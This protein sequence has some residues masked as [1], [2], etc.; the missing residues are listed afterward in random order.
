MP[1]RG[2][3]N[4]VHRNPQTITDSVAG[5][6]H[7]RPVDGAAPERS[8]QQF[9]EQ[10]CRACSARA[11]DREEHDGVAERVHERVVH[12]PGQEQRP[13]V[14]EPGELDGASPGPVKKLRRIE[15]SSGNAMNPT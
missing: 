13:V 9:G 11:C 12:V 4:N 8:G 6:E 15:F 3:S 7:D 2:L 10:Q 5:Q 14:V 1:H